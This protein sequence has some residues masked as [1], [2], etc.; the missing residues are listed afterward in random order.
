MLCFLHLLLL[1]SFVKCFEIKGKQPCLLYRLVGAGAR[2][3]CLA[4]RS[5]DLWLGKVS[6]HLSLAL[7]AIYPALSELS[8]ESFCGTD[9]NN[10]KAISP[11]CLSAVTCLEHGVGI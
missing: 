1:P 6:M 3:A 11:Q 2:P 5:I 10:G 9:E 8:S 4:L 7:L